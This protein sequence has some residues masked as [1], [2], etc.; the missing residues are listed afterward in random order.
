MHPINRRTRINHNLFRAARTRVHSDTTARICLIFRDN[1][2][3]GRTTARTGLITR[4]RLIAAIRRDPRCF[5]GVGVPLVAAG[6]ALESWPTRERATVSAGSAVGW[7]VNVDGWQVADLLLGQVDPD[8]AVDAGH[9]GDGD[10]DFL[11]AP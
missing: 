10:R 7:V 3:T 8:F 2:A 5:A 6:A 1:S 11:P 9:R 4:S